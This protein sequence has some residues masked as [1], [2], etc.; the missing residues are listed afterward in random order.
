MEDKKCANSQSHVSHN[1]VEEIAAE[2]LKQVTAIGDVIWIKLRKS[3]WWPAVIVGSDSVEGDKTGD[4]VTGEVRVRIY[5]SYK[6]MYVDPFKWHSEFQ[7]TLKQNNGSYR[8]IFKESLEQDQSGSRSGQVKRK[9]SKTKD[10]EK[11]KNHGV[12]KNLK[13]GSPSTPRNPISKSSKKNKLN[14]PTSDGALSGSSKKP[15]ARRTKVMQSLG[16]I[17]P[18]GSPFR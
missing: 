6:Y 9:V 1:F 16:L 4:R 8:E 18:S 10:V 15:S 17:A 13:L 14:S 11:P 12:K 3:L 5:G 2:N 7:I